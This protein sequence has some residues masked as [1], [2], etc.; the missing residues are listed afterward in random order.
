[1]CILKVKLKC[2]DCISFLV[3]HLQL[4]FIEYTQRTFMYMFLVSCFLLQCKHL[5][6]M[7]IKPNWIEV[8][9]VHRSSS[10]LW[11]VSCYNNNNYCAVYT[12]TFT[13]MQ[14]TSLQ[15]V[16]N[17]VNNLPL[18]MFVFST[19]RWQGLV[20]EKTRKLDCWTGHMAQINLLDNIT[21]WGRKWEQ[22]YLWENEI[23]KW[24]NFSIQPFRFFK[25][26]PDEFLSAD[27]CHN[28]WGVYFVTTILYLFQRCFHIT[29]E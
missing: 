10:G 29:L 9:L 21:H 8:T 7:L 17:F 11:L 24:T 15:S 23:N 12:D 26:L 14:L 6:L 2:F 19:G 3:K 4:D 5:F 13:R 22:I 27:F 16:K 28:Q 18:F 20:V 1:M 25:I